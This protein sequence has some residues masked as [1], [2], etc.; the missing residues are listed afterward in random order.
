MQANSQ[1][2]LK[3]ESNYRLVKERR[4]CLFQMVTEGLA[5]GAADQRVEWSLSHAGAGL[6]TGNTATC[7]RRCTSSVPSGALNTQNSTEAQADTFIMILWHCDR[8]G[9]ADTS[10]S[11]K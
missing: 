5:A 9:F 10:V 1:L 2:K 7:C 11:L 3:V 6:C 4:S 8:M